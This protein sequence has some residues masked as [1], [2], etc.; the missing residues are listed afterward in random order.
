MKETTIS[1][2]LVF[3]GRVIR[4]RVDEV[5]LEPDG[6]KSSREVVDHPGAVAVVP[7][8]P[9][10][11]VVLV[12]QYRYA[13]GEELTEI[14]AGTLYPGEDP[15]AC[16]RRELAEE[17]GRKA[18]GLEGLGSFYTSPG[19]SGELI[20]IYL[21]RLADDSGGEPHPDEDERLEA[22]AVP[23]DEALSLADGGCLRDA[24]TAVGL[25]LAARRLGR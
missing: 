5:A 25:L 15:E 16:A 4:L 24:K 17:T 19:F 14:P 10:G 13:A 22:F 8:L 3:S 2:K 18:A 11:R 7:V 20:H 23:L 21:A 9:D 1:S 12:R 6:R